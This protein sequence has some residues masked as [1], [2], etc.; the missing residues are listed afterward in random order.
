MMEASMLEASEEATWTRESTCWLE[1]L[2]TYITQ[3]QTA[4]ARQ[5]KAK[6]QTWYLAI[7]HGEARTD[8]ALQQWHQPAGLLLLSAIPYQDLHS[9][10]IRD[11]A[12][13][14]L[15]RRNSFV[16]P[17]SPTSWKRQGRSI[18][19]HYT[20]TTHE[21]LSSR[22]RRAR[23][24][25]KFNLTPSSEFKDPELEAPTAHTPRWPL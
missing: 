11:R 10:H 25:L 9:P 24:T 19:Y 15:R 17:T 8:P 4:A 5:S 23:H 1:F 2:R 14:Y 22:L 12:I 16:S 20:L 18:P 13:K 7:S 3:E 6:K 21:S